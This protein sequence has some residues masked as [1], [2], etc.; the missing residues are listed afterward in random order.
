M[1]VEVKYATKSSDPNL[2]HEWLEVVLNERDGYLAE[3]K[4]IEGPVHLLEGRKI[5]GNKD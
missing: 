1:L 3:V 2:L 5:W 4:L